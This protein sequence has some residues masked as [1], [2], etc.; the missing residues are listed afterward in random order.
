MS[1]PVKTAITPG[2]SRAA[3]VS[4]DRI[5]AWASEDRTS[6]ACSMPGSTMSST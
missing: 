4:I 6:A 5:F 3:V 1:S 2:C